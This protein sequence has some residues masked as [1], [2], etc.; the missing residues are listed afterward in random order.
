MILAAA[1]DWTCRSTLIL[2]FRRKRYGRP[3]RNLPAGTGRVLETA[4]WGWHS[5]TAV[6][7]LR[8]VLAGTF[9]RHP[10]LKVIIG[11]WAKCCR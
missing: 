1:V 5:E 2:T 6:H 4:G 11:Q 10:K 9:D 8:M 3:I 7:V